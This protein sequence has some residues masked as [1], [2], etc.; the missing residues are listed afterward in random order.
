MRYL[1]EAVLVG[2]Y[3][4]IIYLFISYIIPSYTLSLVI[5]GFIKHYLG[6]YLGIHTIY[7]NYGEKCL[8]IHKNNTNYISNN[9]IIY[10]YSLLDGLL[11]ILIGTILSTLFFWIRNYKIK[12]I[13]ILFLI[14]F[15]VHILSEKYFIHNIFCSINCK[16]I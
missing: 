14:G 15:I 11:Y 16:K 2:I 12:Y 8:Q 7:C 13:I 9:N 3:S 6:Y 10:V 1:F 5:V 4:V